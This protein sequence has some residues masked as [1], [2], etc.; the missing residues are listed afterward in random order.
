MGNA[1][2]RLNAKGAQK[3]SGPWRRWV[4]CLQELVGREGVG[5]NGGCTR[6]LH[7]SDVARLTSNGC[8]SVP[9]LHLCSPTISTTII[10]PFLFPFLATHAHAKQIESGNVHHHPPPPPLCDAIHVANMRKRT[11]K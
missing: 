4:L 10:I 9:Q 2:K 7:S 5:G 8:S 11:D 3:G 1:N 6:G